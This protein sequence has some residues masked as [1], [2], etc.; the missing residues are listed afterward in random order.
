MPAYNVFVVVVAGNL[1]KRQWLRWL[2]L[3]TISSA[4]RGLRRIASTT[5]INTLA[6]AVVCHAAVPAA[7][8]AA[9]TF[10]CVVTYR[11]ATIAV[12]GILALVMP[13]LAFHWLLSCTNLLRSLSP[14]H[15]TLSPK[16]ER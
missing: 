2:R 16:I 1:F 11:R 5:N 12:I 14:L 9:A 13:G 3:I 6:I 10:V 15:I 4:L 7:A 8:A